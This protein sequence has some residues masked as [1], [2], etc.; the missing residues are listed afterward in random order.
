MYGARLSA[1][2][3]LFVVVYEERVL[4]EKFGT[5]YDAYC[6]QVGAGCLVYD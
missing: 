4:A 1:I 6:R 2:V 5:E 3:H